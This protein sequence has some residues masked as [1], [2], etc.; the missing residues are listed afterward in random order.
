MD[1]VKDALDK[2]AAAIESLGKSIGS[3]PHDEPV[4]AAIEA[5]SG[6]PAAEPEPTPEPAPPEPS[7]ATASGPEDSADST[8]TTEGDGTV[9]VDPNAPDA[10]S[11]P[12]PATEPS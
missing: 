9:T 1:D 4:A 7:D 11:D 10:S 3:G 6:P 12:T 2:I 8:V 5:V